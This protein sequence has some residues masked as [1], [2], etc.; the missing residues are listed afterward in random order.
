MTVQFLTGSNRYTH[1][2]HL[3]GIERNIDKVHEA[4]EKYGSNKVAFFTADLE[5]EGFL[6]VISDAMD[7]E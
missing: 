3:A 5:S 6:N 4:A 7:E 2:F 1:D